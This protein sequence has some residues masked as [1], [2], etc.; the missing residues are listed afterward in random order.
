MVIGE[1]LELLHL[2]SGA[3]EALPEEEA[4]KVKSVDAQIKVVSL[5]CFRGLGT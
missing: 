4:K 1:T 3:S 5:R 2:A